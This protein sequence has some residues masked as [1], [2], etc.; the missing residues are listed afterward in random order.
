[1]LASTDDT[2]WR[3]LF[4][5]L[6]V[7]HPLLYLLW[8]SCRGCCLFVYLLRFSIITNAVANIRSLSF[9]HSVLINHI[10]SYSNNCAV[11]IVGK[12]TPSC[13]I[14]ISYNITY[15]SWVSWSLCALLCCDSQIFSNFQ[16]RV[17]IDIVVEIR[18]EKCLSAIVFYNSEGYYTRILFEVLMQHL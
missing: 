10:K 9:F 11:W 6:F 18:D 4:H 12:W 15:L 17:S 8:W 13:R 7:F 2:L 5:T 14:S 3:W 16:Y 1:M